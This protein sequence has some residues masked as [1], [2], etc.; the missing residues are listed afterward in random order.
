MTLSRPLRKFALAV[1][2]ACSVGWAGAVAAYL[3]LAVAAGSGAE[4]RAA[5]YPAMEVVGWFVIV[6][7]ALAALVTGLVQSLGT[8]WGLL[9]HY[10]VAA[11]LVLTIFASVVLLVRVEDFFG[12]PYAAGRPAA[13]APGGSVG[14]D[15]AQLLVHSG[16]GLVVLLA[17]TALSVYKPWGR[18]PYGQRRR[19]ARRPGSWPDAVGEPPTG[20]GGRASEAAAGA[21]PDG[22]AFDGAGRPRSNTS[23]RV[24]YAVLAVV[25]LG[26]LVGLH[27]LGGGFRVH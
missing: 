12:P 19:A 25:V 3:A 1:H 6:P 17:A 26:V 5:V 18:T 4:A 23:R 21:D 14:A 11:K 15:R 27:L 10:W 2:V 13:P 7:C 22:L 8:E 9:R 20:D 24:L 16:G